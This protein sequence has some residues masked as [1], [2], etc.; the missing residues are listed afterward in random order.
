MWEALKF[1][2]HHIFILVTDSALRKDCSLAAPVS[3]AFSFLKDHLPSIDT[4]LIHIFCNS[5]NIL[6][7][8]AVPQ[9]KGCRTTPD[10]V[11]PVFL[12]NEGKLYNMKKSVNNIYLKLYS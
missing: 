4:N 1:S 7:T 12:I 3:A 9:L 5:E 6:L 11:F 2:S 8:Q 10:S